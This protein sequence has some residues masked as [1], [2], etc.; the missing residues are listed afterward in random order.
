MDLPYHI[1][2][3]NLEKKLIFP[4]FEVDKILN[5]RS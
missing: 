3:K 5:F 2:D 4:I 1:I